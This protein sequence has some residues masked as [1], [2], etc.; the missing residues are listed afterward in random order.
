MNQNHNKNQ[1][2]LNLGGRHFDLK[3]NTSSQ[4]TESHE[5]NKR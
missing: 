2:M 5:E 4:R 1:R 3:F